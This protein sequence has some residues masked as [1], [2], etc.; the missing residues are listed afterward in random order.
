M[1]I[2]EPTTNDRALDLTPVMKVARPLRIEPYRELLTGHF[3]FTGGRVDP[4]HLD[5]FAGEVGG[6]YWTGR[7]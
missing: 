1:E 3:P 6:T 4:Q 7:R 5:C 2:D